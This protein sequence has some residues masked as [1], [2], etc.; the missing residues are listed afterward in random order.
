MH[1]GDVDQR[2]DRGTGTQRRYRL[3]PWRHPG[4]H[5][6][7]VLQYRRRLVDGGHAVDRLRVRR[8]VHLD[9]PPVVVRRAVI[10]QPIAVKVHRSLEH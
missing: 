7:H 4:E 9:A 3:Q 6:V 2:R 1:D 5:D 10:T 8:V